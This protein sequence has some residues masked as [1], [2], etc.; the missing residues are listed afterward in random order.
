MPV[1]PRGQW[2]VG[3]FL[4]E[5]PV[6]FGIINGTCLLSL[7]TLPYSHDRIRLPVEWLFIGSMISCSDGEAPKMDC[8]TCYGRAYRFCA[9]LVFVGL[10]LVGQAMAQEPLRGASGEIFVGLGTLEYAAYSPDGKYIATCGGAGGFLWDVETG[11]AIRMFSGGMGS[12]YSIVFSP[13]GKK[14]LMASGNRTASLWDTGTGEL[15][16]TFLG[17]NDGVISVAF[18]PD[19]T[20]VLTGNGDGTASLWDAGTGE[21]ILT[22]SAHADEVNS[23]AFSPDGTKVLTG[24]WDGTARIWDV[25]EY[26]D[27]ERWVVY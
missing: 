13:D 18:S 20:K 4:T 6:A 21:L 11:T 19:E 27:I 9:A 24:S 23:V 2:R 15:I 3:G 16:R 8:K 10:V 12:A 26:A 7:Y 25:S 14:V 22:F 17:H 5:T 1:F